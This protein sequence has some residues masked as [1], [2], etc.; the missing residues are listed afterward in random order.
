MIVVNASGTSYALLSHFS[1]VTTHFKQRLMLS[2]AL[3]LLGPA[4]RVSQTL[5]ILM[6]KNKAQMM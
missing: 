2:V 5:L 4:I 6:W 3:A 1:F